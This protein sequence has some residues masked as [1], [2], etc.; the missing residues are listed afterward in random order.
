M[1]RHPQELTYAD[2]HF[3]IQDWERFLSTTFNGASIP[4]QEAG[5]AG[6]SI[7][8][9]LEAIHYYR[10][11]SDLLRKALLATGFE[12]FGGEHALI[13]GSNPLKRT[14]LIEIF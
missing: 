4:A 1:D 12:V 11:N 2:G 7:L 9:Q 6:L 8:P 3:V 14:S 5:V 10:E 13:Y